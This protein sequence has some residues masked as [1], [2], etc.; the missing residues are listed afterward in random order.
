[1][2]MSELTAVIPA[3][4]EES[5]I[6]Q[7]IKSIFL[8]CPGLF[9]EIIVVDDGSSDQTKIKAMAAGARVISHTGNRGY[10]AGLKTGI[11][12]AT[13]PYVLCVDADGQHRSEDI[14]SIAAEIGDCDMAVGA[15]QQIFHSKLWRMPGKWFLTAMANYLTKT[16]IPDLNSGL[17]LFKREVVLRYLHLCPNGFSFSTTTTLAMLSRGYKVKY[18]PI[19]VNQ[20]SGRSMVTPKTGFDAIV[21]ILRITALFNPLRIFIPTSIIVA[22]VGLAWGIPYLIWGRGLSGFSGLCLT[23]SIILMAFGLLCDQISQMR[24]ER[25]E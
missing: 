22:A 11:R 9:H 8:E 23:T 15:R 25:F 3:Y 6:E 14:K 1:M 19:K 20:R 4:N 7:V 24:Q 12:A 13:T 10:G 17:R 2:N 21:T 18:I 5:S 16:K